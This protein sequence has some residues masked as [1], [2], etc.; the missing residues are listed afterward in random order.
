MKRKVK[1]AALECYDFV[2]QEQFKS[3]MYFDHSLSG[4][5]KRDK[6]IDELK[7]KKCVRLKRKKTSKFFVGIT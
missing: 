2:L 1:R 5:P 3:L 6:L 4:D 7:F